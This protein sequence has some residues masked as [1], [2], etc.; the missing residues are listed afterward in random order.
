ML[1]I[2]YS[3]IATLVFISHA[4]FR[5]I[6]FLC[7]AGPILFS[8]NYFARILSVPALLICGQIHVLSSTLKRYRAGR[9]WAG[10]GG[11][12][13][14]WAGLGGAERDEAGA[15]WGEGSA[16]GVAG[17]DT[18]FCTVLCCRLWE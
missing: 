7:S 5:Y 14:G 2:V 18:A 4:S 17:R 12:G 8:G 15:G 9:G 10:L 3:C 16:G 11:A 13:R 6:A 1:K